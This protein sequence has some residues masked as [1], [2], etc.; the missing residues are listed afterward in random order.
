MEHGSFHYRRL[1][2]SL[3][4]FDDGQRINFSSKLFFLAEKIIKLVE[5]APLAYWSSEL[6][7]DNYLGRES[8]AFF[9]LIALIFEIVP[10]YYWMKGRGL[11][12][13]SLL[14][15][16]TAKIHLNTLYL[17]LSKLELNI[18]TLFGIYSASL[19]AELIEGEAFYRVLDAVIL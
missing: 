12:N 11:A 5:T 7:E 13:N 4:M 19:L 16:Y 6:F 14:M 1:L 8:A 2:N 15:H 17:K 18:E 9:V 10:N 3:K